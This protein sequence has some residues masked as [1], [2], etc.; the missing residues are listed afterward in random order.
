MSNIFLNDSG[1][2]YRFLIPF[3]I[4]LY[5]K[6]H[7]RVIYVYTYLINEITHTLLHINTGYAVALLID[8]FHMADLIKKKWFPL[9]YSIFTQVN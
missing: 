7:H 8:I 5:S 2:V 3:V 6:M 4:E 9:H 1:D